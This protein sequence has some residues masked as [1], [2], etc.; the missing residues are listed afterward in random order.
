[1]RTAQRRM[2]LARKVEIEQHPA[3]GRL[4]EERCER[5]IRVLDGDQT[6]P[7]CLTANG[8]PI[9]DDPND[10]KAIKE[11]KGQVDQFIKQNEPQKD[12]NRPEGKKGQVVLL[13]DRL[14][15]LQSCSATLRREILNIGRDE[16]LR[17]EL[18]RA[19]IDEFMEG[20]SKIRENVSDS[21]AELQ[22]MDKSGK[23]GVMD[24]RKPKT[25]KAA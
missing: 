19:G 16:E 12:M 10:K 20:L 22:A 1:M 11:F 15:T 21:L 24:H 23:L 13:K 5:L 7:G 9:P 2:R 17:E 25:K 3:L 4:G 14:L 6:V 18:R 8:I